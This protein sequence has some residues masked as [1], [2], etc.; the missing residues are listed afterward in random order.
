[1]MHIPPILMH[2]YLT[3]NKKTKGSYIDQ[4]LNGPVPIQHLDVCSIEH[5]PKQ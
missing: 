5:T 3:Y 1:M 4:S 2:I